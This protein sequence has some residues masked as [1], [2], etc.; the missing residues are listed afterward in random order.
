[1]SG[2]DL[3]LNHLKRDGFRR[4]F[5]PEGLLILQRRCFVKLTRKW[6]IKDGWQVAGIFPGN[7]VRW[8]KPDQEYRGC[9][10]HCYRFVRNGKEYATLPEEWSLAPEFR[11]LWEVLERINKKI[12]QKGDI[13][14]WL[15]KM[16]PSLLK[17][18]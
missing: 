16:E 9:T 14:P 7:F 13:P 18:F 3:N 8:K 11:G 12:E 4:R 1:L 15:A 2:N 17:D 10:I 5:Y 6:C